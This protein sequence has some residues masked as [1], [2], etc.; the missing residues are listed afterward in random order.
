[1]PE[2]PE[3]ETIKNEL[4]P[5]VIG[6]RISGVTLYWEKL[7]RN[8]LP[9]EFCSRIIGQKVTGGRRRGKY[10]L[11]S[12]TSDDTLV[13][14]LKMSG[15]LLLNPT[16][17]YLQKYIR[18][19]FCLDDGTRLYFRDPRKFGRLWLVKD[20]DS[21]I[22][23]LGPEPLEADF[24]PQVLAELLKNHQAPVKAVLLDQDVIA[25]I[26][27]MY[28]DEALFL[29]KIHPLRPANSLSSEEINRLQAAIQ[30]ILRS[31]ISNKG[32]SVVNYYRPDGELGTAHYQ[33]QVAHR[34][35]ENCKVCRTPIQRIIVRGRGTYICPH[36]QPL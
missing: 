7:V 8:L 18:A 30:E 33:F 16:S 6:R 15:A 13:F 11:L 23:K 21:V 19:L 25:G 26:G 4:L 20:V 34:R 10:L 35:G 31:A 36:C 29:A 1:M 3:V 5:H 28:A 24:T 12:L 17:P 9:E 22:G 32:A 14:H 2:L 27:N